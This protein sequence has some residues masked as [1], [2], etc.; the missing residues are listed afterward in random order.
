MSQTELVPNSQFKRDV[1]K[2]WAEL[3]T[4]EWATVAYCLINDVQMPDKHRDHALTGNWVGF[5]E[6]HIKPD[7]VLIYRVFE[8]QLQLARIGSHSDLF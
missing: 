1:K 6:C 4:T 5:R 3:L 8:N 2:R 7:L